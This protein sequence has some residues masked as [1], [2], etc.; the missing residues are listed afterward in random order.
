M[1]LN[2]L[3]VNNKLPAPGQAG[4]TL[5]SHRTGSVCCQAAEGIL[6]W[7]SPAR[8]IYGSERKRKYWVGKTADVL[9]ANSDEGHLLARRL[10]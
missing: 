6:Q 3:S 2:R 8:R 5:I 10:T 7:R 4:Q 1:E 9:I